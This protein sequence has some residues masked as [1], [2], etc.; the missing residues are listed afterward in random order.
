MVL[1][2]RSPDKSLTENLAL[3]ITGWKVIRNRRVQVLN[4][5]GWVKGR[6]G[7]R[8]GKAIAPDRALREGM[9]STT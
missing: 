8:Q 3:A 1:R 2:G 7:V 5:N 9:E 4:L 6:L